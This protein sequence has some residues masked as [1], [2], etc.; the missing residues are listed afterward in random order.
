MKYSQRPN[1]CV[2]CFLKFIENKFEA[3]H[4]R[5]EH[6]GFAKFSEAVKI[7]CL[8]EGISPDIYD[9]LRCEFK[10]DQ[11]DFTWNELAEGAQDAEWLMNLHY[12]DSNCIGLPMSLYDN[13]ENFHIDRDGYVVVYTDGACP[14]NGKPNAQAGIG[15]WFGRR[16]NL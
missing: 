11:K 5:E 9:E 16:H 1:Q 4:G 13:P 14:N 7:R 8:I 15:V 6:A 12:K 2:T 3:I 10:N